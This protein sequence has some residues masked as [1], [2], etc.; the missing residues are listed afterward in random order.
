MRSLSDKTKAGIVGVIGAVEEHGTS[1]PFPKTTKVESVFFVT[2]KLSLSITVLS[3][4]KFACAPA[5]IVA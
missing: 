1:L 3:L 4:R 2:F 5:S